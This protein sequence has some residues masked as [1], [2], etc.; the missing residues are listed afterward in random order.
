MTRI[1]SQRARRLQKLDFARLD[2]IDLLGRRP[3]L[4]EEAKAARRKI[5]P[6]RFAY[7]RHHLRERTP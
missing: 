7:N 3:G 4:T 2:T 6:L 1:I 5:K